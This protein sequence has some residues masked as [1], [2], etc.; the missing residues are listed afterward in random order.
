M[1]ILWSWHFLHVRVWNKFI[2]N[3]ASLTPP[4]WSQCLHQVIRRHIHIGVS[5]CIMISTRLDAF[6][7][8]WKNELAY[9]PMTTRSLCIFTLRVQ[10]CDVSY[11]FCKKAFVF[12][13]GC[14]YEGACLYL[15][16]LC[17]LVYNGVQHILCV[18]FV[19]F[20]F[21]LCILLCQFLWIVPF[22]L[23]LRF[24]LTFINVYLRRN[25]KID[26]N[27]LTTLYS[28]NMVSNYVEMFDE[29][30]FAY[31]K[32]MINIFWLVNTFNC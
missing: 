5:W 25:V 6:Y 8:H 10:C 18:C 9:R 7:N 15:R 11:D 14:L 12:T 21:V 30:L 28:L 13:S 1:N 24:S 23:P 32:S 19:L 17:L 26:R 3:K 31:S 4:F 27:N 20:F 29:S 2:K 16:Y 22:W